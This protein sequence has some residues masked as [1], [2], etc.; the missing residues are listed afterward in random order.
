MGVAGSLHYEHNPPLLNARAPPNSNTISKPTLSHA[1]YPTPT[2]QH[3]LTQHTRFTTI[4][5][6][7]SPLSTQKRKQNGQPNLT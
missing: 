2:Y 4:L 6:T 1:R 5:H 7:Q 3:T